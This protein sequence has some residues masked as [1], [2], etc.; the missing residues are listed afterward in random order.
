V[1]LAASLATNAS[2]IADLPS[3]AAFDDVASS[4][5]DAV[6]AYA[7]WQ[8]DYL[9]ALA[10]GDD[11]AAATLIEDVTA[12]REALIAEMERS[13]TSFGEALD[14]RIVSLSGEFDDHLADLIQ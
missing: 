12:V 1:T 13:L 4:A 6:G 3:N 9:A 14:E 10:S 2:L 11:S 5:A 7:Q 8:E